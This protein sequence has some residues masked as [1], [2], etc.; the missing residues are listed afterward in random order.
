MNEKITKNCDGKTRLSYQ[1]RWEIIKQHGDRVRDVDVRAPG[2]STD[3][4]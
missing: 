3:T 1:T 4:S 2:L